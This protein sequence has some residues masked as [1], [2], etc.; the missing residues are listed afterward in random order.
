[1]RAPGVRAGLLLRRASEADRPGPAGR[2]SSISVGKR[3]GRE[4]LGADVAEPTLLERER[5][6]RYDEFGKPPGPASTPEIARPAPGTQVSHGS[7]H[8]GTASVTTGDRQL[9]E[10]SRTRSIPHTEMHV[11]AAA[12]ARC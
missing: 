11:R 4:G 7:S 3:R 1:M 6:P 12:G 9:P 5:P 10:C 8:H 2:G